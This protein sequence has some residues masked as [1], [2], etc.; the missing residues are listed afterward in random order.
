MSPAEQTNPMRPGS[1]RY[2]DG[3]VQWQYASPGDALF[4]T[5]TMVAQEWWDGSQWKPIFDDEDDEK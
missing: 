4:S 5:V 3:T 2:L 1:L